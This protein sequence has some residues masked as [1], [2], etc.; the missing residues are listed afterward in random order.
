MA[1]V[2]DS[3]YR[4]APYLTDSEP[5]ERGVIEYADR[6]FVFFHTKMFAQL[7]QDMEEVAG[8]VIQSRIKKFGEN[9]GR[10][11]ASKMDED[12]KD[13]SLVDVVKLVFQ[14]GFDIESVKGI[15]DTDDLSQVEKIFGYGS[16]VGWLGDVDIVEFEEG[17]RAEFHFYNSFESYSYA[18]CAKEQVCENDGTSCGFLTGVI[19]GIVAYY[20][21]E[22]DLS[23]E[24]T[25]CASNPEHDACTIVVK[26]EA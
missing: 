11:I 16:Y 18:E 14:S 1:E 13:V 19:K 8:P 6:R 26:N 4:L 9:A 24:E 17:Q 7:F 2:R 21:D 22:E 5:D 15:S 25:Q 10:Y 23:A 20:W 3:F 12:F